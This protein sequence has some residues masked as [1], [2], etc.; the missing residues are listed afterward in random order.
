LVSP[1]AAGS[2]FTAA[3]GAAGA[4]GAASVCVAGGGGAGI[5]ELCSFRWQPM[6]SIAVAQTSSTHNM[7]LRPGGS[8]ASRQ[9]LGDIFISETKAIHFSSKSRLLG[10]R[11]SNSHLKQT[12]CH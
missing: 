5:S 1:A 3:G 10:L 7:Y 12:Q 6:A 11:K 9:Q 8:T 2:E 4:A